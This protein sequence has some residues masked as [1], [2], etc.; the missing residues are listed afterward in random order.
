VVLEDGFGDGRGAVGGPSRFAE[1]KGVQDRSL[2]AVEGGLWRC[3]SG[4]G[5]ELQQFGVKDDL[6]KRDCL[7]QPTEPGPQ[8]RSIQGEAPR[9]RR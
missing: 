7:G 3:L 9:P 2:Q 4:K 1:S 8:H 6:T 5:N